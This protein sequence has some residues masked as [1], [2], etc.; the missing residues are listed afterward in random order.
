M[1]RTDVCTLRQD[2][3]A[4]ISLESLAT[5]RLAKT[6]AC[7]WEPAFIQLSLDSHVGDAGDQARKQATD[8]VLPQ[9]LSELNNV[10]HKA[11]QD[12]NDCL[13]IML[14][15][16]IDNDR[17]LHENAATATRTPSEQSPELAP[18]VENNRSTA[19]PQPPLLSCNVPELVRHA[20][21]GESKAVRKLLDQSVDPNCKDDFGL[22][23]LHGAAKKGHCEVVTL[24]LQRFAQ[25]NVQASS[26][27]DE[28]PLHYACKYGRTPV[29]RLLLAG[30]ADPG[31][32]TTKGKTPLQYAQD[33]KQTE[34][35]AVF[36]EIGF[37]SA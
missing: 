19:G 36:A 33:K 10:S 35:A 23:A 27:H 26:L 30:G 3:V 9:M 34:A 13:Q 11:E 14:A 6:K 28:T 2:Q 32:A 24:L 18:S 1:E 31:I 16:E 15:K 5:R 8:E 20:E 21:R 17:M 7:D 37:A 4:Y 29:V 12:A 25:V 22:T